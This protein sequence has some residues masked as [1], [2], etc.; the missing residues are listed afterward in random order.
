MNGP[1]SSYVLEGMYIM[2][3]HSNSNFIF[4]FCWRFFIDELRSPLALL[5][6][7][8]VEWA[9]HI[10]RAPVTTPPTTIRATAMAEAASYCFLWIEDDA[11]SRRICT[12]TCISGGKEF[13][14]P[15]PGVIHISLSKSGARDAKKLALSIYSQ[16][17][18]SMGDSSWIRLFS[19][20]WAITSW[21]MSSGIAESASGSKQDVGSSW[22][23]TTS[24]AQCY[25]TTSL[26]ISI[27]RLLK[28]SRSILGRNLRPFVLCLFHP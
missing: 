28:T 23:A 19:Y 3:E 1:Y 26:C 11:L 6:P 22:A 8:P 20:S 10:K 16:L 18:G 5:A 25:S 21:R 12:S 2:L 7:T 9:A 15:L 4:L 13:S 24:V 27:S 14:N 17:D